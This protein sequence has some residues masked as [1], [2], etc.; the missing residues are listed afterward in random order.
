[1]EAPQ[2][3]LGQAEFVIMMAMLTSLV[4]LAIDAMLPAMADI[5]HELGV[6]DPTD[7]QLIVTV[8]FVGLGLGQLVYGPLSDSI[9]RKPAVYLGGAFFLLGS[10]LSLIAQDFTTMLIGRGLQG[11]GASSTRIV[12]VALVRDSLSGRA[13]ARIMSFIMAVFILVPVFAPIIGQGILLIGDWRLIF[14]FLLLLGA[15]SVVWFA[16]R[17]PETLAVEKRKP[18]TY[19]TISHGIGLAARHRT[20]VGYTV[21]TGFVFAPFLVYLS[22]AQQIFQDQY[23][24]GEAFAFYFAGG[25]AMIGVSS[26][27]NGRI[28]MRF[29]MRRLL[30]S[31]LVIQ[32]APSVLLIGWMYATGNQPSIVLY[33]T[34][35]MVVFFSTGMLFGN[36][37]ALAMEPMG[38]AAGSA[39]AFVGFVSSF[40]GLPIGITFGRFVDLT[41]LPIPACFA[42]CAAVA[43][44]VGLWAD[45]GLPTRPVDANPTA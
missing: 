24:V 21:A 11:F 31:A 37:N 1:M 34:Y 42:I 19:R 44:G 27:L 33:M 35:L 30:R 12:C 23:G 7:N 39:A 38:E 28:V 13:M 8:L 18:F 15:V 20:T 14:G 32:I 10:L 41:V 29:G 22:S 45:K 26:V 36:M 25:A 16:A 6:T 2:K 9:G 3:S 4:A 40:I 5:G 43:L 17:Q